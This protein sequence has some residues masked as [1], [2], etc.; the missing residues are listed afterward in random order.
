[1]NGYLSRLFYSQF[2]SVTLL[3]LNRNVTQPGGHKLEI[4]IVKVVVQAHSM[5]S[6]ILI[7]MKQTINGIPQEWWREDLLKD[8]AS[9]T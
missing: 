6:M 3:T 8:S 7:S 4:V 9:I 2:C 5:V 1:M